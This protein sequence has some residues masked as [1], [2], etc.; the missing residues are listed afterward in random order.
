[1]KFQGAA[2]RLDDI[3]LPRLGALIGVGEDE[4]HAFLEVEARGSGFDQQGRLKMLFEPHVFYRNLAGVKRTQAVRA[5]LAYKNW[6]PGAYPKDSYPRLLAALAIDETAA[7]KAC[8][9]GIGQIL[10]ENHK[11]AGYATPQAMVAAFVEDE[12]AQLE[13]VINFIRANGLADE[14]KR[15]D[16]AGFARGYNGAG[17]AKHGYHTKLAAA[18]RKW[19]GI[20][21]TPLTGA[22]PRATPAR[23]APQPLPSR[24]APAGFFARLRAALTRTAA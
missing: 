11:A 7:L 17:Y 8:S 3:D 24:P 2:K 22:K 6:K 19:Q 14:L 23:P 12:E 1:M 21:D 18:F 9:W 4:L 16:W 15:H 5:G 20:P 13:G 10:G